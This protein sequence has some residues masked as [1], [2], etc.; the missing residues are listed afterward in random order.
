M[1]QRLVG[2]GVVLAFAVAFAASV[3]AS[4]QEPA[5]NGLGL[6]LGSLSRLSK[7]RT[8]SISPES[9][10]GEKGRAGMATEG[11]GAKAARELGRGWKV[12]PSIRIKPK[13]FSSSPTSPAQGAIQHIWMTPTGNWRT[14]IL[15]FYW[16]GET[17]PSVE[18]PAG[19]FFAS[20]WGSTR[21]CPRS[22]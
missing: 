22:R 1:G 5:F 16:D 19:D 10:T 17:T 20:G 3:P 11:T 15:R 18:V 4:A 9:F 21:R 7:A 2:H 14:T 13:T 12:S 8:R 6:G